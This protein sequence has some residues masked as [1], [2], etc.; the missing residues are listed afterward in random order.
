M[1]EKIDALTNSD[2]KPETRRES[3]TFGFGRKV[4]ID[5]SDIT[6]SKLPT[7]EQVLRCY[8]YYQLEL[9]QN[10]YSKYQVAVLVLSK[11]V[12]FYEKACVPIVSEKRAC[13]KIVEL[14]SKNTHLREIPLKRRSTPSVLK[15]LEDNEVLMKMTFPLWHAD[16]EKN[17]KNKEDIEFLKSMKTDRLSSFGSHDRVTAGLIRRRQLRM[18]AEGTRKRKADQEI[19]QF[20]NEEDN[21]GGARED[22]EEEDNFSTPTHRSHHR[23]SRPG[24]PA[25]VPHNILSSHKLVKLATRFN[26]SPAQQAAYTSALIEESGG[27]PAKI[28]RSYATA[29][30]ARVC[31][32]EKL[33]EAVKTKWNSPAIASLHWDGKNMKTLDD[34]YKTE[35]RLAVL[36]GDGNG[37]KLLGTPS[38][39][40]G[41]DRPAGHIISDNTV[42]LLKSWNCADN[43]VNLVFDTTASNTGHVTAACVT[44]QQTLG[45]ALLWSGCRHHVGELIVGHVFEDLKIE[46]SKAPEV[47]LFQRFRANYDSI[48]KDFDKLFTFDKMV[49]EKRVSVQQL[50]QKW[51]EDA[52]LK[53]SATIK[54]SREDYSEFA[55]LVKVFL[56]DEDEILTS[57]RRPGAVHKARWM[58]KVLYVLKLTML[59]N[60]ISNLPRGTITASHQVPKLQE[61]AKFVSLVYFKWWAVCASS[62]NAPWNDLNLVK[63][64]IA[65]G[66]L[67]KLVSDSAKL[68]FSRHLWYLTA[69]M[70]PLS[71]F[72]EHVP[73]TCR[74]K[75]AAKLLQLKPDNDTFKKLPLNR[76]GTGFG[77]PVFPDTSS[78]NKKTTLVDLLT[79]D[80][81]FIFKVLNLNSEF[82]SLPIIQWKE[83]E[84]YLDAASKVTLLNVVNDSAERG[85]KLSTDYLGCAKLEGRFQNTLQVVEDSRKELKNLRKTSVK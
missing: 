58:G 13:A 4:T 60:E 66:S 22:Q 51:R 11:L 48:P 2:Q 15:K 85:I 70:V 64:I 59:E 26:L 7:N 33:A 40:V 31:I 14:A 63:D 75:M 34:K 28:A 83:S 20:V 52:I 55:K 61:F 37:V 18:E 74:R 50:I 8:R 79:V 23:S 30:R 3:L 84:S 19:I 77:K 36:V 44:I 6:G 67:N 21:E 41:T 76:F 78:L 29:S 65:Y 49:F 12:P 82:L 81:W 16:A 42:D 73:E 27:N 68:A 54:Y 47:T 32:S 25:F 56:D 43:I 35:E 1:A 38:Y 53:A 5:D 45:R 69:E 9:N 46:T 39:P 57:F 24:T 80:S 62:I 71:L 10:H 17:M 72:S